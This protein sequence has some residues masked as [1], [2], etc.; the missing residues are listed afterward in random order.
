[1]KGRSARSTEENTEHLCV[2]GGQIIRK[3][4]CEFNSIEIVDFCSV[5][6]VKGKVNR[7]LLEGEMLF[8]MF[9]IDKRLISGIDEKSPQVS[10]KRTA[11][12]IGKAQNKLF[13]EEMLKL[14]DYQRSRYEN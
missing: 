1:M 8:A 4:I 5:T 11:I 2:H 12:P 13:T 7:E 10:K 6:Y 9:K 14:V 3:T